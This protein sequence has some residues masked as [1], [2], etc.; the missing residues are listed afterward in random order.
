MRG[1]GAKAADFCQMLIEDFIAFYQERLDDIK[2]V[3]VKPFSKP[4]PPSLDQMG[5]MLAVCKRIWKTY[6]DQN[7]IPGECHQLLERKLK[8]EWES[9]ARLQKRH[10][11]RKGQ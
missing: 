9:M 8:K 5:R 3:N 6:C 2:I 10:R 7:K 4:M 11:T 1:N